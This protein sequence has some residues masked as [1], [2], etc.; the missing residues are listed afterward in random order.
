MRS[1]ASSTPKAL[2]SSCPAS[3]PP[4][5]ERRCRM[6]ME[7]PRV[8][9][10]R[11]CRAGRGKTR[12]TKPYAKPAALSRRRR[13]ELRNRMRNR[14]H[15]AAYANTPTTKPA[16]SKRGCSSALLARRQR[17]CSS[18]L[19]ARRQRFCSSALLARRQRCCSSG[20]R[21][22]AAGTGPEAFAVDL[23][24]PPT[25]NGSFCSSALRPGVGGGFCSSGLRLGAA[26]TGPEAF[27]LD[28][29]NPPNRKRKFL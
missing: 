9:R 8:P 11:R 27:A 21:P 7:N 3:P 25:A 19:L 14:R 4:I 1:A 5:R 6:Q 13:P 24:N 16:S 15:R 18:A 17:F 10:A 23:G 2:L 29:G 22:G 26:G 20:L 28:L 12:A